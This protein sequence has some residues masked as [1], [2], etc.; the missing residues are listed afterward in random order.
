LA[1]SARPASASC[2]P[3]ATCLASWGGAGVS[4]PGGHQIIAS[5]WLPG[6]RR[7]AALCDRPS[8]RNSAGGRLSRRAPVVLAQ[9]HPHRLTFTLAVGSGCQRYG[10]LDPTIREMPSPSGGKLLASR[11]VYRGR[12]FCFSMPT[13]AGLWHGCGLELPLG[14]ERGLPRAGFLAMQ[15]APRAIHLFAFCDWGSLAMAWRGAGPGMRRGSPAGSQARVRSLADVGVLSHRCTTTAR[16]V[17]ACMR[18][19]GPS[20]FSLGFGGEKP[21]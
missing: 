1:A 20:G 11:L 21:F 10:A 12:T 9:T 13:V 19:L 2:A 3:F 5:Y 8:A 15:T 17:V 16:Q 4:S 7:L 6:Q 18:A 14:L